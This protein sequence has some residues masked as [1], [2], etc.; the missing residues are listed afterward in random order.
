MKKKCWLIELAIVT[1]SLSLFYWSCEVKQILLYAL[2]F[3][4]IRQRINDKT[5]DIVYTLYGS[6]EDTEKTLYQKPVTTSS[7]ES[8]FSISKA[9]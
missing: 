5:F 7:F 9:K 4:R 8:M 6:T 1:E 2:H 3:E